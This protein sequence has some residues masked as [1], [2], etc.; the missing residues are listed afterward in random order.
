MLL[1]ILQLQFQQELAQL[2]LAK[3][4][5]ERHLAIVRG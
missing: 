1:R 4:W 5:A 2:Q 3:F